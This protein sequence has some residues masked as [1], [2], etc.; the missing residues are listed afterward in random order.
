M[1]SPHALERTLREIWIVPNL[2]TVRQMKKIA[3]E[4]SVSSGAVLRELGFTFTAW[5]HLIVL[6]ATAAAEPE[7]ELLDSSSALLRLFR[8]LSHSA[9]IVFPGLKAPRG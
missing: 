2:L 5:L 4:A 1:L 7:G 9:S 6:T 8:F 3:Q